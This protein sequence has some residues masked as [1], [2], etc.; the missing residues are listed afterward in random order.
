MTPPNHVF[1]T[2]ILSSRE[3][4]HM[5][6]WF[7]AKNGERHGPMPSDKLRS[8]ARSGDL[9]P[10]DLVWREGMEDWAEARTV[11]GLFAAPAPVTATSPPPGPTPP[12]AS[13]T[14][15]RL[16]IVLGAAAA[17]VV[18]SLLLC[19]GGLVL[20]GDGRLAGDGP[21]LAALRAVVE[22]YREMPDEYAS[23]AVRAK[24][25]D[26]LGTLQREFSS[27]EFDPKAHPD[28]ARKIVELF[29]SEVEGRYQGHMVDLLEDEVLM[30]YE[31]LT[32]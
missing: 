9:R 3:G 28:E 10:A 18:G 13:D 17:V 6:E 22:K 23:S 24:F 16:P 7:Y 14:K 29:R 27:I 15:G 25:N 31:Q 5:V 32:Q 1:G 19:C 11:K 4:R 2:S 21:K 26:E 12:Q 8:L 30:I 20:I